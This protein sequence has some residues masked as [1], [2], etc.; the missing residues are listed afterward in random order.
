MQTLDDIDRRLLRLLQ[1]DASLTAGQL[2]KAAGIGAA[3]CWRRIERMERDGIIKGRSV[4]LD[5]KAL[6]YAVEVSL[7]ITLDKTQSN[8]F[9]TFI[10]EARKIPEVNEIQTFLGRVDVRLNILARDM[11][12]YQQ[13]YRTQILALPHLADIEALMLV[14][15]VKNSRGLPI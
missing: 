9:D 2:A 10:A 6:G 13:I 11:A 5:P 14:S 1:D 12:H 15:N 4:E 8:A 3:S 7:R